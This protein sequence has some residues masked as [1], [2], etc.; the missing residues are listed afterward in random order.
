MGQKLAPGVTAE[1]NYFKVWKIIAATLFGLTQPIFTSRLRHGL[2]KGRV[3]VALGTFCSLT[4]F[5]LGHVTSYAN[6]IRDSGTS[7]RGHRS[8]QKR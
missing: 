8:T 5:A 6:L 1:L 2:L 4:D 3:V 7:P